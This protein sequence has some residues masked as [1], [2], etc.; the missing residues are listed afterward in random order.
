MVMEGEQNGVRPRNGVYCNV[1]WTR[2]FASKVEQ[3]KFGEAEL[4]VPRGNINESLDWTKTE[5]LDP[6]WFIKRGLPH[7]DIPNMDFVW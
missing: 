7:V 1:D 3:E 5:G 6:F 4:K 2:R